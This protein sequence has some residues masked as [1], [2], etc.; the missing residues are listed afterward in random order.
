MGEGA[1]LW[2]NPIADGRQSPREKLPGLLLLPELRAEFPPVN[3]SAQAALIQGGFLSLSVDL[4]KYAWR[5]AQGVVLSILL[6]MG[7]TPNFRS[8]GDSPVRANGIPAKR[9]FNPSQSLPIPR[10]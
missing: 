9:A 5:G 1:I 2:L 7:F 8:G 10:Y 3:A 4:Q 6:L